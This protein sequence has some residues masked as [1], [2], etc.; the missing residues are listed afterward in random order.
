[1][2]G[3]RGLFLSLLVTVVFMLSGCQTMSSIDKGLASTTRNS[4]NGPRF[5]FQTRQQEIQN[6]NKELDAFLTKERSKGIPLNADAVGGAEYQEALAIFDR[7][8]S[9]LPVP[10]SNEKWTLWIVGQPIWNA[11]TTGGTGIVIYSGLLKDL[12]PCQLAVVL[13]HESAHV[14][15]GHISKDATYSEI[16]LVGGKFRQYNSLKT[17]FTIGNEIQ[18]DQYGLLFATLAGFNPECGPEFWAHVAQERG[19]GADYMSDH[20][21]N[22][23]RA[24]YLNTLA[25]QYKPYY[26]GDGVV[27]PDHV[28]ILNKVLYPNVGGLAPGQGGGLFDVLN[29]AMQ[30]KVDIL[31]AQAQQANRQELAAAQQMIQGS[32]KLE[33][34]SVVG[35]TLYAKFL[36]AAYMPINDVF[37]LGVKV[38]NGATA[39]TA[40]VKV[41][42]MIPAQGQLLVA[43][44]NPVFATGV[45][46][47]YDTS[48]YI[49]S[50]E[51]VGF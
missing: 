9:V 35:D 5:D 48:F 7:I 30:A 15:L 38:A 1:M 17:Y 31:K 40:L 10:Y 18:A 34:F 41:A 33:A 14:V 43:F 16:A 23:Q 19:N 47:K 42:T 22:S 36:N 27:N 45:V 51:K 26:A 13:G 11:F 39:T 37:L 4:P 25:Q 50:V 24:S 21:F 29:A 2:S 49:D 8:H 12:T 44:R 20:P 6:G 28:A 46:N 3:R 32:L